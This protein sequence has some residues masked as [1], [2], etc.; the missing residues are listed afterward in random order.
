MV[1]K[2]GKAFEN[3]LRLI[4]HFLYPRQALNPINDLPLS[5]YNVTQVLQLIIGLMFMKV[6]WL[7][8]STRSGTSII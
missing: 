2:S 5:K 8:L 3:F 4:F 1:F 6:F 7:E